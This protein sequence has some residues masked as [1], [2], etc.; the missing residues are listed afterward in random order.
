MLLDRAQRWLVA[1]AFLGT[2]AAAG[3]VAALHSLYPAQRTV[4]I[5]LDL[6]ALKGD[7]PAAL[8]AAAAAGVDAVAI[9]GRTLGELADAGVV[10][11]ARWGWQLR[12]EALVSG[13]PPPPVDLADLYVFPADSVAQEHLSAALAAALGASPVA[14]RVDGRAVLR[15][16]GPPVPGGTGALDW[17]AIPAGFW[18]GDLEWAA[19]AGLV[20]VPAVRDAATARAAL[21]ALTALPA[22]HPVLIAGDLGGDA[23][24]LAAEARRRGARLAIVPRPDPALEALVAAYGG[25]PVKALVIRSPA[26][27]AAAARAAWLRGVG[28]VLVSSPD[29]AAW[30]AAVREARRYGLVS[31]LPPARPA[32]ALPRP[33]LGALAGAAAAG[34]AVV[35]RRLAPAGAPRGSRQAAGLL[36]LAVAAAG[37][38]LWWPAPAAVARAWQ[39]AWALTAALA[40][41]VLAAPPLV[42]TLGSP[43]GGAAGGRAGARADPRAPQPGEGPPPAWP[44][45][46][47]GAAV[48]LGSAVLLRALLAGP[49]YAAEV[50]ALPGLALRLAVPPLLA[51]VA[52]WRGRAIPSRAAGA[53]RVRLPAWAVVALPVPVG[54][55][56]LR[57]P[58]SALAGWLDGLD[59]A[60][61]PLVAA[62]G[63]ALAGLCSTWPGRRCWC[64]WLG[65]LGA[66]LAL[67]PAAQPGLRLAAALVPP[68]AGWALGAAVGAA[69]ARWAVRGGQGLPA[70]AP[71]RDEAVGG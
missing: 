3:A 20:P 4:L 45:A 54:L 35:L 34:A 23:A 44:A 18:R 38:T 40:G 7:D 6:A 51:A 28:L 12:A 2:V 65:G 43:P 42:R 14:D 50:R 36:V 48:L 33:L 49:E 52:E 70:S 10:R 59:G 16:D 55:T 1:M 60:T 11:E 57:W 26:Q 53:G 22:G 37:T 19:A 64:A 5:A 67:L 27:A 63:A 29:P 13:Q 66:A 32:A 8:R 46:A 25:E 47:A 71:A 68:V 58:E 61:V 39:E 69:A 9:P 41:A 17:R 30:E 24:R 62:G 21:E 56:L 31:G 15:V